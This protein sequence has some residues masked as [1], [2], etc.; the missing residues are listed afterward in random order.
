VEV[1][2]E[3]MKVEEKQRA[4]GVV[5]NF[6]VSYLPNAAPLN[7]RQ[8]F[9]L[10]WKTAV[11]PVSFGLI[12]AIAGGEQAQNAYPG[13]GQGAQGYGKRF[14]AAYADFVAGTFLGGAILPAILKQDPRYFYKGTGS[15]KSRLLYSLGSAVVCKG[16]NGR[17][18]ANYSNIIGSFAAGGIS[19]LY[20]PPSD[21]HGAQLTFENGLIAIGAT[22]AANLLQEFLIPKLSRNV[23]KHSA[24]NP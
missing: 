5:P 2:Q 4:L 11:D 7:A 9:E 12:A 15:T 22:G 23:P 6:Y 18:Q 20:Y 3:Q 8:K 24:A 19:N 14:G 21:R 1:A 10:A 17:W 13:Y 16:D